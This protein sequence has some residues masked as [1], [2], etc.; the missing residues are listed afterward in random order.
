LPIESAGLHELIEIMTNRHERIG[1]SSR[2]RGAS[3]ETFSVDLQ[4]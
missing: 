2:L 4:T 1:P 3:F